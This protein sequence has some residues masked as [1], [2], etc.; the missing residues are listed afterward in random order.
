MFDRNEIECLSE[1]NSECVSSLDCCGFLP[2]VYV[3]PSE[4]IQVYMCHRVA[5]MTQRVCVCCSSLC[6]AQ[7]IIKLFDWA[8]CVKE[9]FTAR[10]YSEFRYFILPSRRSTHAFSQTRAQ[11]IAYGNNGPSA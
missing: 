8:E 10:S 7:N 4:G 2:G 1:H 9:C 3:C 5:V 6:M 11:N